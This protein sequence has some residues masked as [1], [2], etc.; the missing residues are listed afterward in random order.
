MK[1]THREERAGYVI[2][3]LLLG[4]AMT[5]SVSASLIG[6]VVETGGDNEA[7][8]TIT[9]KWTGQTWTIS[10][11]NEPFPGAV[12]G[13]SFT[14][15][16]FGSG[17]PAFVDRTHR[18][19]D[20]TAN[21]LPVPGYLV[22]AD[23][24]MSGNDNRDNAEYK[25]DITLTSPATVYMLIDNRLSDGDN[26]TP[27]TFDAT[28][29]QWIL[30]QGWAATANGLNRS[31]NPAVPDEVGFDEATDNDIDQWYSVYQKTFDAGTMTILQ[32]DNGG[33]NMYGVVVGA[34]PEPGTIA[35]LGLGGAALLW[36]LRRKD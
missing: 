23:Y 9:A 10:V 24:I 29:M 35:L 25:L 16:A 12:I 5:I 36:R 2:A 26:S 18:Y 33:R 13:E 30:D 20:D 34:V 21:N 6:N 17:A 31:A 27:P 4:A 14:V 28:H 11:A 8:D 3:A 22:G 19:F 1:M 7:T 32:A 15:P